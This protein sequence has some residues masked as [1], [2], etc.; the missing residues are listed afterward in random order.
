MDAKQIL[1]LY[2]ETKAKESAAFSFDSEDLLNDVG[3]ALIGQKKFA[4]AVTI[5]EYNT[6]LFPNSANV[7][8]SLGEGYYRA[9]RKSEA[10]AN[11]KKAVN[12]DPKLES[13]RKMIAELTK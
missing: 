13:A 1:A 6:Q 10:L 9:G 7:F 11:Y 2:A 8:D 4:D 5:L 12:L 3:Y